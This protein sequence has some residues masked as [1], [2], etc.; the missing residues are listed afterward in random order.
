MIHVLDLGSG[1]DA[2][3]EGPGLFRRPAL[4]PAGNRVAAEGYPLII[5]PTVDPVTG[6]PAADTTV[7]RAGDLYLFEAP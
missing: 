6:A 5:T 2:T 4:A 3:L 1:G 7:A